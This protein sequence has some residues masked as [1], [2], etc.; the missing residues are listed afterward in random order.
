MGCQKSLKVVSD[1]LVAIGGNRRFLLEWKGKN[2]VTISAVNVASIV[3]GAR[4]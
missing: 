3:G 4:A 1:N 2:N